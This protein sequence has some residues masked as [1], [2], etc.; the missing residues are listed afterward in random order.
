MVGLRVLRP[1]AALA[2]L[3]GLSLIFGLAACGNSDGDS[4]IGD[5][6]SLSSS[7]A[8]SPAFTWKQTDYVVRCEDQGVELTIDLPNGWQARVGSGA[9][10]SG[11]FQVSRPL[12]SGQGLTVTVSNAGD[13]RR[14]FHLRCLPK[15][16]P[17]YKFDRIRPGGP[18]LTMVELGRYAIAFDRAGV[19]VWWYKATGDTGNAQFMGDGTF[20]YAPVNGIVSREFQVRRLD[21]T[22]VRRLR[23]ANGLL[24]DV[25]DLIRLPNGN[26]MLGAHRY[27]K[28][29]DTRKFGGSATSRIDTA[30]VQELTPSGRLVWKW[31]AWPRIGLSQ[32]GRW[33]DQVIKNG[34]PYDLDHWNSVDRR[35]D[36]VLLS[37]RHLDAVL[38]V[39]RKSGR[40]RWKLG[41]T[42]TRRSLRVRKDSRRTP[43]G[44]Q[45]DARFSTR[46]T[47]TALDNSTGLKNSKPRAVHYRIDDKARTATLLQQVT[48]P[49]VG[50]S[51]GFASANLFPDGRWTIGWGAIGENGIIGG[52]T[53]DGEPAYRLTTPGKVSYRANPVEGETPT[54]SQLRRAMDRMAS[55]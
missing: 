44:G 27:V 19:P 34:E 4:S 10:R 5:A 52:Y 54:I 25:H 42:P 29:V 6:P 51:I 8:L 30:Q 12:G 26:Y 41:G 35:G 45:H 7:P 20:S 53:R 37:F 13:A 46:G 49:K 48:D 23:A 18:R 2:A 16:F 14:R 39:D 1:K 36:Q 28:G 50:F 3:V 24:T 9:A 22:L 55:G 40:I 33:W 17:V 11:Q 47:I 31:D 15:D 21:G 43:L 38:L 32:T